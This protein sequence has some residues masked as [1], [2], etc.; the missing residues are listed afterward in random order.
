MSDFVKLLFLASALVISSTALAGPVQK[1]VDAQ[2]KTHYGST[3]P[4]DVKLQ[5][6]KGAMSVS[7]SAAN[8]GPEVILYST[9]RCGYCKKARA[10][11]RRND[12]DF[13]EYDI[14]KDRFAN[15]D[16]KRL[17]GRGVPLLVRG[18][19]TLAGFAVASY[20]RFFAD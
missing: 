1:W 19:E 11:M 3:P 10:Y 4:N 5:K 2:G 20:R 18:E 9:A 14:E 12:I 17:G 16:Y 8:S 15:L 13:T 7:D 6:L